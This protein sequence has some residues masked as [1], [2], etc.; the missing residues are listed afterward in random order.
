MP[1]NPPAPTEDAPKRA[2]AAA[3]STA[4]TH[5]EPLLVVI[6]FVLGAVTVLVAR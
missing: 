4:K 6:G 5:I 3:R 2:L 1:I